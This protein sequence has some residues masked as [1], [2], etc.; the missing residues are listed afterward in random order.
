MSIVNKTASI[1]LALSVAAS[2]FAMSAGAAG[3]EAERPKLT[4][5]RFPTPPT[6]DGVF[7]E[8]E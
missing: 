1:L 8:S 6:I 7:S 3:G 5:G 2:V 4:I